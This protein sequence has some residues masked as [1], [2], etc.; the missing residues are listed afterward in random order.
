LLAS[1]ISEDAAKVMGDSPYAA[2]PVQEMMSRDE[3]Q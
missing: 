2:K 1:K 3:L